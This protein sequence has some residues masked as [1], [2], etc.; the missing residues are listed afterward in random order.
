MAAVDAADT[1]VDGIIITMEA[2]AVDMEAAAVDME[3]A[4]EDTA[5]MEAAAEDTAATEAVE[6]MAVDIIE[7]K[8]RQKIMRYIRRL[9]RRTG[10][11]PG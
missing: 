8:G 6:D 2:A 5:T 7:K 9:M 1:V 11:Y 4:A 10:S 3:A